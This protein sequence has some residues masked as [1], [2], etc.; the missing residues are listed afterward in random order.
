MSDKLVE[1]R[2]EKHIKKSLTSTSIDL[3]ERS[4]IRL[5]LFGKTIDSTKSFND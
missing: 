2:A 3:I 4:Y 1:S 5:A